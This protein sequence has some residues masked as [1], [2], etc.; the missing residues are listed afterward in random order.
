[1]TCGTT[2]VTTPGLTPK[3]AYA[4]LA[5]DEA[6][7]QVTLWNPHGQAFTPKGPAGLANGYPTKDGVF[8]LP[9]EEWVVQFSGFAYEKT[10]VTAVAK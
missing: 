8:R 9:V 6:T 7:D 5:Y 4:V 10:A 1:M 3:H 2:E